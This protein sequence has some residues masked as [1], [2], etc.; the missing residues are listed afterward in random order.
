MVLMRRR[1]EIG[2]L[3]GMMEFPGSP[4][5]ASS[6]FSKVAPPLSAE[7]QQLS[8]LVTHVFTHF[9]LEMIVHRARLEQPPETEGL[10]Q[11]VN[12]LHEVALPTV[13]KKVAAHVGRFAP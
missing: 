3:G 11:P 13:M 6:D 1:P 12:R 4:W 7:W 2:L 10:W 9:S 5:E 8:G